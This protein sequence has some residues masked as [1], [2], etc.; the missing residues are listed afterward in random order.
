MTA[1]QIALYA[2]VRVAIPSDCRIGSG[3]DRDGTAALRIDGGPIGNE[4]AY[5][6]VP[7]LDRPNLTA[8]II[9]VAVNRA[10]VLVEVEPLPGYWATGLFGSALVE[11]PYRAPTYVNPGPHG[12]MGPWW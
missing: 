8:I 3:R 11:D 2:A 9:G 10:R 4:A 1:A 5:L 7:G 12:L 6:T